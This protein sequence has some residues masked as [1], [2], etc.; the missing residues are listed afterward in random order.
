M[1]I[2]VGLEPTTYEVEARCSIQLSYGTTIGEAGG[3]R[4][5]NQRLKRPLLYQLSYRSENWWG[6]TDSNRHDLWSGDFKSPVSTIPPQ[7]LGGPGGI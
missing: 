3:V 6:W 2:P 5:H 7:P 1:A 4:S